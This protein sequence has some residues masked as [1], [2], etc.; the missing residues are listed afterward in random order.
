MITDPERE[1]ARRIRLAE[2]GPQPS[3]AGPLI[4]VMLVGA[5][6]TDTL[7][8]LMALLNCAAPA[9][10]LALAFVWIDEDEGRA[11]DGAVNAF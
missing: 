3:L 2:A 10:A 1:V 7:I 8:P 4:P 6:L 5:I 9:V 11:T